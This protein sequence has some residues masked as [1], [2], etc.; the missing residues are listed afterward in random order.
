MNRCLLPFLAGIILALSS[1]V[2]RQAA[3]AMATPPERSGGLAEV[4]TE[5][6]F[7]WEWFAGAGQIE[8]E[9]PFFSGSGQFVLRMRRDSLAWMA[10][11]YAGL[12]VAR[13]QAD[14]DSVVLLNRFE[15][16][17]DTYTWE[18]L[19]RIS[20]FPGSL[21]SLQRLVM[22]LLPLVP[23]QWQVASET[24]G[25]TEVLAKSGQIQMNASYEGE[26]YR[27]T[28]CRIT[29][30][31]SGIEVKGRQEGWSPVDGREM[32]RARQW[33]MRPEPDSRVFLQVLLEDGSF[34]GPLQFPF[35][36]PSRYRSGG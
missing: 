28:H 14:K 29:D 26:T 2:P 8:M 20:G 16:S 4:V 3:T 36:V 11:R 7:D 18:E 30:T 24:E 32:P 23:A 35:Q 19:A 21:V 34:Q 22:G 5:G 1:C 17:V 33:E 13:L 27:M 31:A 12:E 25:S 9:S 15:G 10:I 6:N